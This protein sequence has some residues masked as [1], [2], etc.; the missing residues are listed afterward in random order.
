M[1]A[2][3][4]EPCMSWSWGHSESTCTI[5]KSLPYGGVYKFCCHAMQPIPGQSRNDK[6]CRDVAARQLEVIY[7]AIPEG[8]FRGRLQ[9][10][11]ETQTHVVETPGLPKTRYVFFKSLNA[12]NNFITCECNV[13]FMVN[14]TF[15]FFISYRQCV[16]HK[17]LKIKIGVPITLRGILPVSRA[18]ECEAPNVGECISY[19]DL[20][21][22]IACVMWRLHF[23]I[24]DLSW[25]VFTLPI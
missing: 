12:T 22:Q 11:G 23:N 1:S 10:S 3:W 6:T 5:E 8:T 17:T 4:C 7:H 13:F 20:V 24:S 16:I 25:T 9:C 19:G 14:N 15:Y 18:W 21:T 2:V